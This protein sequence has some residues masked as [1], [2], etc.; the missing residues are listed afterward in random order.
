MPVVAAEAALTF[1]FVAFGSIR[2]FGFVGGCAGF[3]AGT[4]C[5][6]LA[7]GED[8]EGRHGRGGRH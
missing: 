3:E 7:A 1:A 8:V 2:N 4:D 6:G 5:G